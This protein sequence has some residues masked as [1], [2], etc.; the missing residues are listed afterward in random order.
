MTFASIVLRTR[1]AILLLGFAATLA[2]AAAPEKSCAD[3][4]ATIRGV[5]AAK[6]PHADGAFG[7]DSCHVDH[8]KSTDASKSRYKLLTSAP[9]ELCQ[10]CHADLLEGKE[11]AH[12]P[13]KKDCT[14]CHDPHAAAAKRLR[15]ES[16]ALCLECHSTSNQ[17]RFEADA[18]VQLFGGQVTLAAKPFANLHLLALKNDRGHPVSHHPVQRKADAEWPAV[19]CSTCHT[20]H[21]AN[22]SALLTTKENETTAALCQRCHK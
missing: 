13:A 14:L 16:N 3:C 12:E 6:I 18:P 19:N 10:T 2:S 15:A 5:S 7:C 20:P 1:M 8:M 4:H 21:G 17:A 9:G 22:A 11:F